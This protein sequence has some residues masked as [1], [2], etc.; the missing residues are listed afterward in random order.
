MGNPNLLTVL[1][2]SIVAWNFAGTSNATRSSF[3]IYYKS[4]QAPTTTNP[5]V[6]IGLNIS[7]NNVPVMYGYDTLTVVAGNL[8][9]AVTFSPQNVNTLSTYNFSITINDPISSTGCIQIDFPSTLT[10]NNSVCSAVGAP[11]ITCNPTSSSMK[12]CNFSSGQATVSPQTINLII[13]NVKNPK[14]MKKTDNFSIT[15]YY[16]ANASSLVAKGTSFG[17]SAINN[18]LAIDTVTVSSSNSQTYAT[19]VSYT[20]K[21]SNLDPIPPN[22][23]ILLGIPLD[24]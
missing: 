1:N 21:F 3:I 8:S 17:I 19:S 14:S 16:T 6:T 5:S 15:T 20:I 9:A 4:Y 10:L 13:T 23:W 2:K 18:G 11:N 22:G 12:A 7:R 24:V